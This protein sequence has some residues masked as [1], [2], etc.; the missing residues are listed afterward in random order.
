ME[1]GIHI[2]LRLQWVDERHNFEHLALAGFENE[3]LPEYIAFS[4]PSR[5]WYPDIYISNEKKGMIHEIL[6]PNVLVR[7]YRNGTTLFSTRL[8]LELNCPMTLHWYP[9]DRHNC[10][11]HFA[12]YSLTTEE[13]LLSWNEHD[14]IQVQPHYL[15]ARFT[16]EGHLTQLRYETFETEVGAFRSTILELAFK[17][18]FGYY[19]L[20]VYTPLVMLVWISWISFWFDVTAIDA[21]VSLGITTILTMAT[22]TFGFN[23]IAPVVSY[24]KAVDIFSGTCQTFVSL[25]LI[26]FA[27][28]DITLRKHR[29]RQK[30][31]CSNKVA[32]TPDCGQRNSESEE[33]ARHI[34]TR[35]DHISRIMFP[36][37]FF[38][39]LTVYFWVCYHH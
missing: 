28:V 2:T 8:S 20:N 12:S 19:L 17:R 26:E 11:V 34:A 14:P 6:K 10:Y 33:I 38:G 9:F 32:E 4:D 22:Q 5:I 3:T 31:I 1:L 18:E 29:K 30:D 7:V 24:T 16:L 39:F 36:A 15:L 35:I 21:R 23:Q 37:L 25:A 13:L 27:V